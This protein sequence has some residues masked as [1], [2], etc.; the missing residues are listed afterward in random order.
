M[1][2][3][4]KALGVIPGTS[5][6]L[7]APAGRG[8]LRAHTGQGWKSRLTR[9]CPHQGPQGWCRPTRAHRT[10]LGPELKVPWATV[11]KVHGES[12]RPDAPAGGAAARAAQRQSGVGDMGLQGGWG[13]CSS[14]SPVLWASPGPP[15]LSSGAGEAW[16][17]HGWQ[18]PQRG[19][20]QSSRLPPLL[21]L[22]DGGV[23]LHDGHDDPVDVVLKA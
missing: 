18:Q 19:L 9:P 22:Q 14:V 10:T 13:A 21:D 11:A 1:L 2:S 8:W 16:C 12:A 20:V 6:S 4:A 17:A 3:G 7:L 15:P 23:G 5:A